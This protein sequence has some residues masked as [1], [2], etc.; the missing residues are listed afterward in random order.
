MSRGRL[1]VTNV[2]L[3]SSYDLIDSLLPA[4]STARIVGFFEREGIEWVYCAAAEKYLRHVLARPNASVQ[5]LLE[6][7]RV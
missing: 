2:L 3:G 4:L 7:V 5:V 6:Q 1:D